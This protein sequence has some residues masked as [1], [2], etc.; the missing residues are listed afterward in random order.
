[1]NRCLASDVNNRP[2]FQEIVQVLAKV[3]FETIHSTPGVA[4]RVGR[5]GKGGGGL[6]VQV[7]CRHPALTNL[8]Q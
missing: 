6:E 7:K 8:L 5:V 2:A 1:M 3:L 4:G